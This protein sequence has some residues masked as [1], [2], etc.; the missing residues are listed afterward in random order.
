MKSETIFEQVSFDEVDGCYRADNGERVRF[1]RLLRVRLD[2]EEHD[3]KLHFTREFM[4]VKHAEPLPILRL[5]DG[6]KLRLDGQLD[7]DS[8]TDLEL[9][10]DCVIPVRP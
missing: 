2:G 3:M 4:G 5:D 8:T 10:S 9:A 6:A 1:P 7:D